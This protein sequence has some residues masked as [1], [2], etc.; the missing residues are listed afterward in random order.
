VLS[1]SGVYQNTAIYQKM[2][3]DALRVRR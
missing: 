3:V 2:L 1:G